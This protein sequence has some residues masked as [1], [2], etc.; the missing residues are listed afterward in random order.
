MRDGE[1]GLVDQL[2]AVE[3]QV[4]IERPRAVLAGDADAA[5]T[6]LDG[7]QPVEELARGERRLEGRRRR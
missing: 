2:V 5:E 1:P 6:L 7:E 3:E 4:E